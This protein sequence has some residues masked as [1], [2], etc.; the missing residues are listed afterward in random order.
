[1]EAAAIRQYVEDGFVII[2]G[3]LSAGEV[4]ELDA[5]ADRLYRRS[6][7]ID[8]DNIRC[9]W[10]NHIETGE[11]R[12]D[13]FDPVIDLSPACERIARSRMLLD[14]VGQLYGE[15]ACLF[16]ASDSSDR[17]PQEGVKNSAERSSLECA[18]LL[19]P[20]FSRQPAAADT[21]AK[22]K[23]VLPDSWLSP[24]ATGNAML[25]TRA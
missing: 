6:D 21:L 17:W 16:K 14:L 11:C 23:M 13:C 15:S 1:L 5:E 24:I 20:L 8:S 9:R 18:S 2:R 3:V 4:S 25:L 7:L 22:P 19:A 10:Q 12:F